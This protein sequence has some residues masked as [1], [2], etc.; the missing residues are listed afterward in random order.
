MKNISA[1]LMARANLF[2]VKANTIRDEFCPNS[3]FDLIGLLLEHSKQIE[4]NNALRKVF[5]DLGDDTVSL[6]QLIDSEAYSLK[7]MEKL[8]PATKTALNVIEEMAHKQIGI[9]QYTAHLLSLQSAVSKRKRY[10]RSNAKHHIQRLAFIFYEMTGKAPD[11]TYDTGRGEYGEG[12][13]YFGRFYDFLLSMKA[14]LE[15]IGIKLPKSDETIGKYASK[16]V[17]EQPSLI[18]IGSSQRIHN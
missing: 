8:S 11:C 14:I 13:P 18:E 5:L 6:K 16:I 17:R 2:I 10:S 1:D 4:R 3:N 9:E 15:E 12:K 7:L